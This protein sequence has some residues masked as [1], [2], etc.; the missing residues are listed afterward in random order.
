MT[1]SNQEQINILNSLVERLK[2]S[3]GTQEK[4]DILDG[5]GNVTAFLKAFPLFDSFIA[6]CTGEQRLIIKSLLAIG[7][8]SRI[9]KGASDKSV[10]KLAQELI[11]LEHFYQ[12]IG[13]LI[14]YHCTTLKLLSE[15]KEEFSISGE[16]YQPFRGIDISNPQGY[17]KEVILRGIE[18][19]PSLAEIYP[20]G[21]A[22]DRLR[23]QDEKTGNFLPAAKLIFCGK[24]L[25]HHMI[26]DLQAR[27]Y[28]YF[29]LHGKQLTTPIAMMTSQEKDNHAQILSIFEQHGWYGRPK[30]SF[31]FFSQP[32]VP[33]M[34]KNG[35]WCLQA[36]LQLLLKPGGHGVIWKLAYENGVFDWF[37]SVGR[38]K[39]LVR[40]INNL[41]AGCDYGLLAF[42]GIGCQE[43]KWLGFASC[44]RQ[45]KTSEGINVLIEKK[46]SGHFEYVLTNVEYCDFKKFKIFDIPADD[47]SKFS[48][49]SSNTN[50]LF[51][52]LEA[53]G[54]VIKENPFPGMLVNLKK[55]QYM[56]ETGR[57][58]EDEVVRLESTMQNIA[59]CFVE[60]KEKPLLVENETELKTL[61]TF[62]TYN[63]RSKTIS[64]IKREFV[65]GS[66]LNET[67]EGCYL[68]ILKNARDLLVKECQFEVPEVSDTLHFFLYGPSFIF[69]YHPALGP[70]YSIIAQKIK[71]GRIAHGSELQLEIAE[72]EVKNLDLDGS[73]II[74]AK[75]LMGHQDAK[76][77]L[78]YSLWSGKCRLNNVKVRN[79]GIN[80]EAANCYWKN[81]IARKETCRI[82]IHGNGEFYAENVTLDGNLSIEVPD[83]TRVTA[84]REEGQL[85][86]IQ[87]SL[88]QTSW[89]WEYR[90]RGDSIC[91]EM[92]NSGLENQSAV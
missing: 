18:E 37:A 62:L 59:D 78:N 64:P 25:L 39:A 63:Q 28:L 41:V 9:F 73:L 38:K 27:E 26:A 71:K 72:I 49:F 91:L 15:K 60:T 55:M 19:L 42:T 75:A 46:V 52:D 86:F 16:H 81:E 40:Q 14:G 74:E 88:K 22:A 3:Q 7:Q 53:I 80:K 30:E 69:L 20:V 34:D 56:D 76:D 13:G 68:D 10:E 8:G 2:S 67:P 47:K 70:L 89:H 44:P 33:T 1:H 31:Q 87:T 21:G 66:S 48:K 6:R 90:V 92:K 12:S 29:K 58:T 45:I 36:P 24:T 82:L 23:L 35:N 11:P 77:I 4:L 83:Q 65:Y 61:R 79:H 51:V 43:N 85:K 5:D 54:K 57:F 32:L 84:I 17:V 50:L